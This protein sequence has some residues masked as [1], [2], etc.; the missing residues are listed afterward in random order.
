MKTPGRR[1]GKTMEQK[2]LKKLSRADLLEML[3]DQSIEL[4]QLQLKYETAQKALEERVI[5]VERAGSIAEAALQLNGVFEAAQASAQQYLVSVEAMAK[6]QETEEDIQQSEDLL[7]RTQNRCAKME[8]DAKQRCAQMLDR[9]KAESQA[10]W[11]EV[12]AKLDS[13]YDRRTPLHQKLFG[14]KK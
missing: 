4:Q 8:E 12:L 9:A 2:D 3:L 14:K 11:D 6:R 5:I 7:K 1:E 13:Y 10:Y